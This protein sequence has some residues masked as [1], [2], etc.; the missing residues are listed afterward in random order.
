MDMNILAI[1]S[2]CDETSAAIVQDGRHVLCNLISS[3]I[4]IHR[5]FGG[6]VPEIAS[7]KHLEVINHLLEAALAE[8]KLTFDDIHL[9]AVTRGPGLL[10]ALLVGISA[11]KAL[12][13]ML[14]IPIVGVNHMVGHVSAN[15]LAH[16]DLKPPF[17]SLVVSGGHTYFC[18]VEDYA[19]VK[20]LGETVDD[21]AGE[22]FDKVA[23]VL[24]L[25]YPGGPAIQR[26][27]EAGDPEAFD[28]PR[29]M[30]GKDDGLNVSFSGLK[31]AVIN[32]V[33]TLEQKGEGV[34][35]SDIAA[36]F[37]AAVIDTLVTKAE[38]LM[39]QYPDL[40]RFALSGGVAANA[41]LQNALKALCEKR[42][43]A[44]YV[45]PAILCTDN[46]AMIGCAGYYQYM[47]RG[48]SEL[49]FAAEPDLA[50]GAPDPGDQDIPT[51]VLVDLLNE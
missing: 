10:G 17:L 20:I 45:P 21:A 24:G 35:T 23:R 44:F 50:L 9:V 6:V 3:Q 40:S 7:R 28:F 46:A 5:V 19:H 18:V 13:F 15:Y 2:S 25:G 32:T 37:Q 26:A 27:A 41:A 43:L 49:D 1:E 33:H 51:E 34:P 12:S 29:A 4:D 39:D 14:D 16:P 36:S 42:G 11:A 22:S 30:M 38:R 47:T 8:A 31:T 48:T